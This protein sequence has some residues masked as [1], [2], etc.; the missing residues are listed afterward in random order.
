MYPQKGEIF[1]NEVND[2]LAFAKISNNAILDKRRRVKIIVCNDP[3][4]TYICE[5]NIHKNENK[6]IKKVA[7]IIA[8][9]VCGAI[10]S[11][12]LLTFWALFILCFD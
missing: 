3:I 10:T 7:R 5:N 11:S 9:I 6:F 1:M 8:Y 2:M 4:E 12:M